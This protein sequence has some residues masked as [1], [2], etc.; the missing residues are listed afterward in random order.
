M[1]IEPFFSI[2]LALFTM[3]FF[4]L[5][6][7]HEQSMFF[8]FLLLF[9]TIFTVHVDVSIFF[10]STIHMINAIYLFCN[11]HIN[12]PFLLLFCFFANQKDEGVVRFFS[13]LFHYYVNINYFYF[14]H[15][16]KLS[17]NKQDIFHQYF[18]IIITIKY[19]CQK[20]PT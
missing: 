3:N 2:F 20:S 6:C 9:C 5:F 7:L 10:F 1:G 18:L 4:P 16:R 8:A 14:L 12:N 13:F 19:F 15:H 11:I 17:N